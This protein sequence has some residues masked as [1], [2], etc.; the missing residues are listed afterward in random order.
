MWHPLELDKT[1]IASA[2]TQLG[3]NGQLHIVTYSG[4][5]LRLRTSASLAF[6]LATDM[7]ISD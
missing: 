2:C 7:K 4:G 1:T 6:I 5:G 3:R